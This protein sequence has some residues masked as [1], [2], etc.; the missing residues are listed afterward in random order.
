MNILE[1]IEKKKQEI[2][3]VDFK[4]LEL[5]EKRKKLL[6][7]ITELEAVEIKTYL[8]ELDLPLT[9]VKSLFDELLNKKTK[10]GDES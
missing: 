1:K 6:K 10:G 8:T 5:Q 2:E 4:I 3:K 9:E 7:E